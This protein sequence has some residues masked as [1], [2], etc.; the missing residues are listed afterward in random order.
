MVLSFCLCAEV[1]NI[2]VSLV[3]LSVSP[4]CQFR[5]GIKF[6]C[7]SIVNRFLSSIGPLL[8]DTGLS[9]GLLAHY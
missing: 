3:G 4:Y 8:K 1:I 5:L 6:K 2:P 9:F 7:P